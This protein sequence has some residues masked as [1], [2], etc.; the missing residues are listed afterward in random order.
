MKIMKRILPYALAACLVAGGVPVNVMAAEQSQVELSAVPDEKTGTNDLAI[1]E[2]V[3]PEAVVEAEEAAVP[4]TAVESETAVVPETA[5]ESEAY[6]VPDGHCG[7]PEIIAPW[8]YRVEYY[9][10][11]NL[12]TV[13]NPV[14]PYGMTR[15]LGISEDKLPEG[16][17]LV[18]WQSMT[19]GYSVKE[20]EGIYIAELFKYMWPL[21]D[22]TFLKNRCWVVRLEAVL[23]DVEN[24]DPENPVDPEN[25][26]PENPDPENPDPEN[27]DPENPDPENPD[28]ENPDPEN[29][30]PENPDPENPDPENP[31]N[32]TPENPDSEKPGKPDEDKIPVVVPVTP[33]ND[34]TN[35]KDTDKTAVDDSK[36]ADDNEASPKTGDTTNMG[37]WLALAAAGAGTSAVVISKK[38]KRTE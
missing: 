36:K 9:V 10:N 20:G 14:I 22:S 37:L 1:D 18:K 33:S 26:D 8:Y 31:E 32:P 17:E 38:R 35:K 7:C 23:A 4:E 34:D 29:P 30:D 11:G 12:Y 19:N 15:A 13:V 27:P 16:K 21:G 5:V 2:N 28:P 25:P 6:C 24:P 3:A